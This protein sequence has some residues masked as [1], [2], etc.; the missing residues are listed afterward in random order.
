MIDKV[1]WP[2]FTKALKHGLK[3]PGEQMADTESFLV[4]SFKNPF[5]LLLVSHFPANCHV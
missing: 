1:T 2:Q 4:V 3:S 5:S